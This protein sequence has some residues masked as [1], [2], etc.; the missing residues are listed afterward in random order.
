MSVYCKAQGNYVASFLRKCTSGPGK[1]G[2][3]LVLCKLWVLYLFAKLF[4]YTHV[5][6]LCSPVFRAA[7]ITLSIFRVPFSVQVQHVEC[8]GF[9]ECVFHSRTCMLPI[10]SVCTHVCSKDTHFFRV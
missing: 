8:D 10:L 9:H 1:N 3:Y 5:V 6:Y 2:P 4:T 7:M